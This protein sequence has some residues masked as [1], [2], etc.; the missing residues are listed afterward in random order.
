MSGW[1]SA[2]S[3]SPYPHGG[4][5]YDRLQRLRPEPERVAPS[6]RAFLTGMAALVDA[7]VRLPGIPATDSITLEALAQVPEPSLDARL[8]DA[9]GLQ[10]VF[11]RV[12]SGKPAERELLPRASQLLLAALEDCRQLDGLDISASRIALLPPS[13]VS[14]ERWLMQVL[15]IWPDDLIPGQG[16]D[17]IASEPAAWLAEQFS[18]PQGPEYLLCLAVD[19]QVHVQSPSWHVPGAMPG[20]SIVLLLFRRQLPEGSPT[21]L[22]V[23]RTEVA[24]QA[25]EAPSKQLENACEAHGVDKGRVGAL[26]VESARSVGQLR[27]LHQLLQGHLPA[28]EPE[29]VVDVSRLTG[30]I[31]PD[32]LRLAQLAVARLAWSQTRDVALLTGADDAWLLAAEPAKAEA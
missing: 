19:S 26:I 16:F 9:R 14:V 32:H 6:R 23:W 29:G 7:R 31:G 5:I 20:E 21:T 3:S 10:R 15:P 22:P 17:L 2:Y 18:A 11:L 4:S 24:D 13:G 27:Q 28:C 1:R 30:S 8:L 12:D 25:A